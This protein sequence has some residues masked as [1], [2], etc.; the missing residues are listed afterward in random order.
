MAI[1]MTNRM[2]LSTV[3]TTIK[4]ANIATLLLLNTHWVQQFANA[5]CKP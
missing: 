1:T 3:H 4:A 5:Q 2:A